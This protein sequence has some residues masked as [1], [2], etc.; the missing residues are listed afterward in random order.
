MAEKNISSSEN[1]EKLAMMNEEISEAVR[2][3]QESIVHISPLSITQKAKRA[4]E[5]LRETS[6]SRQTH[7][8]RALE[9]IQTNRA[10]LRL[11]AEIA[12]LEDKARKQADEISKHTADNKKVA[13]EVDKLRGI[14]E[15]LNK[16]QGIQHLLSSV[17]DTAHAKIESDEEF[18]K[19][20]S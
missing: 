15:E 13:K 11:R 6:E 16:K 8:Q 17:S 12:E 7:L 4:L 9:S 19:K 14:I 2:R 18:R 10:P 5:E 1:T 20:F 3:L